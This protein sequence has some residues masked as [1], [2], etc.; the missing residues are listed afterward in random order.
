MYH[1]NTNGK[2]AGVA[3]FI[4]G[5]AVF[6]TRK[7]IRNKEEHYM[8]AKGSMLQEHIAKVNVCATKKRA[9]KFMR[10]NLMELKGAVDEYA[11][12]VGVFNTSLSVIGKSRRLK[13]S[14]DVDSLNNIIKST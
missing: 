7:I 3:M 11:F 10:Q 2:R 12:I 6:R 4:S 1:G 13:I 9:S 5:K 14:K 8:T